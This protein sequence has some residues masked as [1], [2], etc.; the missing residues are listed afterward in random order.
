MDLT[1]DDLLH[2]AIYALEQ[3]GFLLHDAHTLYRARCYASAVVLSVFSLE[4][5]GRTGILLRNREHV[6]QGK[7]VSAQSV[8][9]QCSSHAEKLAK[10]YTGA[11]D[12]AS[13]GRP[14]L[15]EA[16]FMS[17]W[18]G[19]SQK[20]AME[21]AQSIAKRKAKREPNDLLQLRLSA[22]YVEPDAS[23]GWNRPCT[24]TQ[25]DCLRVLRKAADEYSDEHFWYEF[26]GRDPCTAIAQWTERPLLP[27]P[28]DF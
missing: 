25:T 10:G 14:E 12:L 27:E 9:T 17:T 6:L 16:I 4:E 1:A 18:G 23:T 3:A 22:L 5:M 11:V 15:F 24:V 20:R 13:L 19:E 8:K 2:G 21:L 26:N 28:L 7:A